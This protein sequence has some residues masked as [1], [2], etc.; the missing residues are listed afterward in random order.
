MTNIIHL[1]EN[2]TMTVSRLVKLGVGVEPV[3]WP[4]QGVVLAM[5]V[6]MGWKVTMDDVMYWYCATP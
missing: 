3:V 6:Y 4:H 5:S 2:A 1:G